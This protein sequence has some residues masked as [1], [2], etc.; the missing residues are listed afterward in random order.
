MG[1]AV[2]AVMFGLVVGSFLNV[3]IHRLPQGQSVVTPRSRCPACG[4]AIR[5]LDNIPVLSY[6]LLR[7]RCRACGAPIS[8]LYPAVE[9]LTAVLFVAA[10][11]AFGPTARAAL[12]AVFLCGLV[13]VTFVDLEHQ[14]I[15]HAVT[16]PGIPLGLL[17]AFFG[18][19]PP[20]SDA[21]IGCLA[22][23]GFIYM[24][25]HYAEHILYFLHTRGIYKVAEP[26]AEGEEVDLAAMGL[27][28][29]NL[30]GMM[31]AFLGW[32]GLIAAF[33]V[34]T[35]TGS[36]MSLAL[37]GFGRLKRGQH[38]PFGPYLALGGGLALFAG[39]AAARWYLGLLRPRG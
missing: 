22:G 4:T 33:L 20:F 26:E 12:A 13:V 21:L 38:V 19:G 28:D 14:I 25:G 11:L 18:A 6:L 24:I 10:L 36:V 7:G 32:R 17:A 15:P 3:C 37:M 1:M 16:L 9:A 23:A 34:A 27:G 8:L 5:P 39:E 2:V 29:V 31:G 30:A 35:L